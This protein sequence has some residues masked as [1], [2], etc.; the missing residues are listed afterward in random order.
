VGVDTF[1]KRVPDTALDGIGPG[2]LCALVPRWFDARFDAEQSHGLLV[3][4]YDSGSLITALLRRGVADDASAA[5][6]DLFGHLPANWDDEWMVGS[7]PPTDVRQ[8]SEF[9]ASAPLDFWAQQGRAEWAAEA[10]RLGYRRPIDD[11]RAAQVL[12]DAQDVAMLFNAAAADGQAIIMV[13]SA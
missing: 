2:A 6:V 12:D 11:Q 10:Q 8:I 13:I 3:G 7:L 1:W 5:A 4:V 9:L